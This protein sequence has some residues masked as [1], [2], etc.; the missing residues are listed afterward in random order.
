MALDANQL[1]ENAAETT[2]TAADAATGAVVHAIGAAADPVGTVRKRVRNLAK[3]GQPVNRDISRR[4]NRTAGR[5]Q[6]TTQDIATLSLPR[7]W[8]TTGIKVVKGRAE[9]RDLVGDVAYRALTVVHEGLSYAQK[10]VGYWQQT[11]EPTKRS[12]IHHGDARPTPRPARSRGRRSTTRRSAQSR[13]RSTRPS[14]RRTGSNA[15]RPARRA[16]ETV[17]AQAG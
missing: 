2:S 12:E 1:R 15:G 11:T 8:L 5:V 9:R 16:A 13:A 10:Q 7:R 6:G 14:A 4:A 17:R 3:Q